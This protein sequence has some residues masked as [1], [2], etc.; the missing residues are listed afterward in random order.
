MARHFNGTSDKI[1]LGTGVRGADLIGL[2][3]ACWIN[4]DS[5]GV[6]HSP[7]A[8]WNNSTSEQW[9]LTISAAGK[10][11]M[12]ILDSTLNGHAA[13]GATTLTAGVW[14]HVAGMYDGST[15]TC[16]VNGAL[17]G[18][19]AVGRSLNHST[20][21]PV[22]IGQQSQGAAWF[23]G[24]IAECNF[25][26]VNTA[27]N[28]AA[29]MQKLITALASTASPSDCEGMFDTEHIIY[30]PLL[31]DSPEPNYTVATN[32]P[33]VV[34]GTTVVPHPGVRTLTAFRAP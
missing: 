18:T 25:M 19:T 3:P 33:G 13:T 9:L 8:R 24:S 23:A 12:N 11:V 7:M 21:V 10:V 5:I 1:N 15:L 22:T 31:G 34:T 6:E 20:S 16:Y 28:S 4:L 30:M 29:Q 17:D 26:L 2:L 14:T 27:V 32:T